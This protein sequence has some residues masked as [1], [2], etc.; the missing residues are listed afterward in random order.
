MPAVTKIDN[1]AAPPWEVAR[2]RL[3]SMQH[4]DGLCMDVDCDTWL[5]IYFFSGLGYF[6]TVCALG[7]RDYFN[8]IDRS[9]GD[10]PVTVFLGGDTNTCPRYAFVSAELVLK[11]GETF[12][13]TA[14][15]DLECEWVPDK[16]AIYE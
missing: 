5:I 8:L 6:V 14:E 16:D 11:A 1:E 13:R 15:R 7:D 2:A 3:L 9:L 12:Y 4:E 10:E